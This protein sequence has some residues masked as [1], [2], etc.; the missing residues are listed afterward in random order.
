L[1][2][3]RGDA[4][5]G[6]RRRGQQAP[7]GGAAAWWG[8]GRRR[9]SRRYDLWRRAGLVPR[10]VGRGRVVSA[11]VRAA[12]GAGEPDFTD[13]LP[14]LTAAPAWPLLFLMLNGLQRLAGLRLA[15]Q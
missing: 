5:L 1:C 8:G 13:L 12:A 10:P 7:G 14:V 3:G 6:G 2:G 15:G 11:L 4:V 9:R